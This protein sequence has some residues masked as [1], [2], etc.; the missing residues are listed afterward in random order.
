MDYCALV[1][2]IDSTLSSLNRTSGYAGLACSRVLS[3]QER[4]VGWAGA[5]GYKGKRLLSLPELQ[6]MLNNALG[7]GRYTIFYWPR[8]NMGT[9]GRARPGK[10]LRTQPTLMARLN[11]VWAYFVSNHE[12]VV[13]RHPANRATFEYPHLTAVVP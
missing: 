12:V 8:W 1:N 9:P 2:P 4:Y 10:W 3:R 6:W 13:S 5:V 11:V 7:E